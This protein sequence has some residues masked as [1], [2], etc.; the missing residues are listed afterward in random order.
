MEF[1]AGIIVGVLLV[2][3]VQMWILIGVFSTADDRS[4]R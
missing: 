3:G 2:M 4:T 1:I